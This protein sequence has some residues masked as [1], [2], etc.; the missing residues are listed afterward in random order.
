VFKIT[1]G[2]TDKQDRMATL[3]ILETLENTLQIFRLW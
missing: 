3:I 1:S 2:L